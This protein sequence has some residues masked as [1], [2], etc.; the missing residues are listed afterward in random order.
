MMP[1]R[2]WLHGGQRRGGR[3]G[4]SKI[5]SCS[6]RRFHRR[7][8]SRGAK[9]ARAEGG[10][11]SGRSALPAAAQPTGVRN[12]CGVP[13]KTRD[14]LRRVFST[15]PRW[16]MPATRPREGLGNIRQDDEPSAWNAAHAL[17]R[18]TRGQT[19]RFLRDRARAVTR[20]Q[21]T[22]GAA[23]PRRGWHSTSVHSAQLSQPA[24]HTPTSVVQAAS[25]MSQSHSMPA[26]M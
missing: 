11:A 7:Q 12:A 20:V 6:V 25:S 2:G 24:V 8:A 1:F 13:R 23:D 4:G 16:L 19:K 22:H 15:Q 10:G 18:S 17:S 5:G 26:G 9:L 14:E 21:L 3:R